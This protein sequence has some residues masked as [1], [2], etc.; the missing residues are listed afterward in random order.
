MKANKSKLQTY[1][2][3]KKITDY[4]STQVLESKPM[5]TGYNPQTDNWHCLICGISMGPHNPRQ[6]CGKTW[7]PNQL[8]KIDF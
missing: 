1:K 6:L 4:Y 7:C 3:Q 2:I 8:E 5:I